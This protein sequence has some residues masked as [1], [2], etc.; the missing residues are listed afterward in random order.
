M[1]FAHEYKVKPID[2]KEK[3]RKR[4]WYPQAPSTPDK[5]VF[6]DKQLSQSFG[7][8]FSYEKFIKATSKNN[9]PE[10]EGPVLI[11]KKR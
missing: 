9:T 8:S 11:K 2:E 7:N 5:V 4:K 6:Y 3:K 10:K 1:V